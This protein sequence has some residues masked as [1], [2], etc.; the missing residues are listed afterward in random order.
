MGSQIQFGL[1]PDSVN[2]M[3]VAILF[4]MALLV[5]A[6]ETSQQELSSADEALELSSWDDREACVDAR[7]RRCTRP[8]AVCKIRFY[9]TRLCRKTCGDCVDMGPT[10]T[11]QP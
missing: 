2:I 11:Q 6:K 10:T 9:R 5:L 8:Q 3:K 4:A 7:P 1:Q